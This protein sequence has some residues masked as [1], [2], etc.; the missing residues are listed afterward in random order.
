MPCVSGFATHATNRGPC[1]SVKR[2]PIA[3][4][5]CGPPSQGR[6]AFFISQLPMK[7]WKA[8][9]LLPLALLMLGAKPQDCCIDSN[10]TLAQSLEGMEIPEEI[11]SKLE[12]I[13]VRYVGFDG[14][15]HRGQ[16]LL[17]QKIAGE[18]TTIFE[19]LYQQRFP[20]YSCIP[21]S[22]FG[23]SD[24]RSMEANNTSAFNYRFIKGSR[25]PSMHGRGLAIDLNPLF[26]PQV[27]RGRIS[28]ATGHYNPD[29]AGTLVAQSAAVRSFKSRGYSWGGSWRTHGIKDYMHFEKLR[30]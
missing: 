27:K 25:I 10:M 2:S 28:P 30:W 18:V 16:L 15:M 1:V 11:S 7:T 3:N 21:V 17:H 6:A 4:Y 12:L 29:G 20:V 23:W 13:D 14:R 8:W 26:N 5:I 22:Q 9:A 19:E 24:D